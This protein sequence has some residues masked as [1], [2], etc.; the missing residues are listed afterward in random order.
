MQTESAAIPMAGRSFTAEALR[1]FGT[2]IFTE[3]TMLAIRSGA[4]NLA[5]GFPDFEGPAG[6]V[7]AAVS[8]LQSGENQ[9]SPSAGHNILT[10][11]IAEHQ[12]RFYGL[13]FDPKTEVTVFCGATEGVASCLLGLLNPGDEVILIQPFYD[14]YPACVAMAHA[15]PRFVTLR[16][17]DFAIDADE[18]ESAFSNRTRLLLLNNPQN[19]T[20]KVFT[21]QELSLI[22]NACLKHDV[23][24]VSDEVYEHITY[25]NYAHVPIATL[26]GMRERTLTLSSTGK[27]FSMTGWK[28]GWATGPRN[29][30]AA[31]QAAHQY[32][33]F[34]AARPLQ[35]AMGSALRNYTGEYLHTLKQEYTERRD[36]LMKVLSDCGFKVIRPQGTYFI[37]ADISSVTDLDGWAFARRLVETYK[38]GSVPLSVFYARES[39][40]GN[41]QLRFAFC[42]RLE[43]LRAAADFLVQAR[44][45]R[46]A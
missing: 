6:I 32:I 16:P 46:F 39:S 44:E 21:R 24:V 34:C 30:I 12:G 1:P 42:K 14:S 36:F 20:G 19:P 37:V 9:Y 33:T 28:V 35:A 10:E 13:E 2:T 7:Q 45:K 25:Q 41:R 27:T 43:T 5:Q 17:P 15:V 40:H 3:M 29:L 18:L 31:A 22:A 23:I 26:P 38:I 8:A 11:A 4:I